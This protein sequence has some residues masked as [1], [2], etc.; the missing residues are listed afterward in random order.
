MPNS[1][2]VHGVWCARPHGAAVS[3]DDSESLQSSDGVR[4]RRVAVAVHL[5]GKVAARGGERRSFDA[6][7]AVGPERLYRSS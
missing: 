6:S 2:R 7:A 4:R 3:E 1:G 5:V